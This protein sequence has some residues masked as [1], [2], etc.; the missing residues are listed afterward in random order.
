[1]LN[2]L[3]A[4]LLYSAVIRP[5]RLGKRLLPVRLW[6]P[7][8]GASRRVGA[9]GGRVARPFVLRDGTPEGRLRA[10]LR[11]TELAEESLGIHGTNT[12]VD[13]RTARRTIQRCPFAERIRDV[14]EFCTAVGGCAGE[15][16]FDAI[17]PGAEFTVLRTKS[18]GDDECE[19]EYRIPARG[20]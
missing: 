6:A 3:R 16:A 9:F 15:G 12:I 20:G 8:E 1:M 5:L 2:H 14:P 11:F 10:L 4:A 7:L 18:R 19:Y 17:V 13:E